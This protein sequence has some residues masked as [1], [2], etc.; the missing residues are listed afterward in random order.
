L[1]FIL[2]AVIVLL[3]A[4]LGVSNL[5]YPVFTP[6]IDRVYFSVKAN[7]T[8]LHAVTFTWNDYSSRITGGPTFGTITETMYDFTFH[9]HGAS[10]VEFHVQ[11]MEMTL[12]FRGTLP[13]QL[14]SYTGG[15]KL[16]LFTIDAQSY[17]RFSDEIIINFDTR[18]AEYFDEYINANYRY[19]YLSLICET[20]S[21]RH[22]VLPLVRQPSFSR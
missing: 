7:R 22:E 12:P 14:I 16:V 11:P 5:M 13:R 6:I 19:L 21:S 1:H 8:G 9:N 3:V 20:D 18:V 10:A 2:P 4:V 17:M 15:E